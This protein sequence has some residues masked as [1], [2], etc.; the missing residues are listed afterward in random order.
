MIDEYAGRLA[1]A[2]LATRATDRA[3]EIAP[4]AAIE[5]VATLL[6]TTA[7]VL[8]AG[9][10]GSA[11][12]ASHC[13]ADYA[14]N[15]GVRALA[16]TDAAMLTCIGNDVAFDMVFAEQVA[17]H[18][19]RDDV[20]VAISCSGESRNVFHAIDS[21]RRREMSVIT[22]TGFSE[23]N[24]VRSHGDINF[25][26]PSHDYGLVEVAHAALAHM[27]LDRIRAVRDT[28]DRIRHRDTYCS[29]VARQAES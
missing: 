10:G 23:K 2:L 9:N 13:A 1:A 26:V 20:F 4:D 22:L 27:I 17:L 3:M 14:R 21:A 18:G 19:N 29:A 6:S 8:F 28:E 15:G 16:L 25:W 7:K 5:R 11:A 12:T 24:T